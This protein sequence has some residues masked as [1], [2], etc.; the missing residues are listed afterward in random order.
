MALGV[1]LVAGRARAEG[2]MWHALPVQGGKD[3]LAA[4]AGLDPGLPAWRVLYESARRRHG[5]WG[6]ETGG[7]EPSARPVPASGVVPLPLAPDAWRWI[8]GRGVV[9]DQLAA[10]ILEDR[11]A[12]LLYRGLAAFDEPTLAALAS[13]L[14]ALRRIYRQHAEALAA[15]GSRF[16]VDGGAVR[17]PGGREAAGRWENL[18][19][20]SSLAPA[21]FLEKLLAA[22]GGRRAFLFDSLARLEPAHQRFAL[23]AGPP[24]G[25]VSETAFRELVQVFDRERA[26]WRREGGA[27]ARPDAD[28]ARLLREVRLGTNGSLAA[29][30]ARAFWKAAFEGG[31]PEKRDAWLA[32]VR[33]SPP[34]DA[35]WLAQ[36]VG[37]GDPATRRLRFEQ[38][39]FAQRVF[40]GAADDALPD[41]LAA[42]R[43]LRDARAAVLTLERMGSRD[44]SLYAAAGAAAR[45]AGSVS[46]RARSL[47]TQGALQGALGLIERARFARTID[48]GE[49]EA[50]ART[51]FALTP[52]G[53][54]G[55]DRAVV[56]WVET[57]LLPALAR[58]VYGAQPPGDADTTVLRAMAG[59][60][61]ER[62]E[63]LA[64]FDW[65]GLSYRAD[66]GRAEFVRLERVRARQ[67]GASLAAAL[68]SCRPAAGGDA[69]RPCGVGAVLTS[70]VYAAHV[71]E[72][73][74]PALAGEDVSHRHDFGPEPWGLP[75]EVAG[76]GV[77]WHVRGSLLGLER[78]L[79]RLSLHRLDG[80]ELPEAPPVVGATQQRWLALPAALAN[81]RDL[82]D[83]DRDALV[84][85]IAS[86]RR[87]A[88]S[89]GPGAADLEGA[90]RDAGL[91]PWRARAL[92]WM[93]EHEA[94][95]RDTF[96]SLGEL[97]RLGAPGDQRW[98]AWGA[99]AELT[100][101]LLLRMPARPLDESAGQAPEPAL[102]EAFVDVPL[103]VAEH[104]GER[105]LPASLGPA[106]VATLL[107]ELCAEARPVALD[108]RL[109][110]DAWVRA[111]P[112]ERLDDALASL[113][114]R[115]PLQPA[116][117][118]GGM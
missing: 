5:V 90:C 75:E 62:G 67:G 78:A 1:C 31:A 42:V 15:F 89:L 14:P 51:L 13:D 84:A 27:F 52:G 86:G 28:A 48:V 33:A 101:G 81:P 16:A 60:R 112:R 76:P 21:R 22:K 36:Q 56:R 106:V 70:F 20:E 83:A 116:P 40:G 18:V 98:D 69:D 23:A 79:G 115:G 41:V 10:A 109:G 85:A 34:A 46:G 57:T 12:S 44:P 49:A 71:G 29:P 102:A 74:G 105:R 94:S 39:S 32:E 2:T 59:D 26:W 68:E 114:G 38:V 117:R 53:E 25:S 65:E 7:A 91:E 107:P 66:P 95:A 43:A 61:V 73:D 72:P 108:D 87:R 96:F 47:R 64:R 63:D 55:L 99:L 100:G 19:G 97:L 37:T 30:S 9:D 58:G 50:L 103:R 3:A 113:A 80:D 92:P 17:L 11:R 77:P 93:L 104:L 88:A 111:L 6:E 54:S 35:A 24:P 118:P 82:D 110:L 45:H 8:M 4:A